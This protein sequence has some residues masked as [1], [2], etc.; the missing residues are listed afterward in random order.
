MY[1]PKSQIQTNLYSN[2]EL[3]VLTTGQL[4]TGDYWSTSDGKFYAGKTPSSPKSTI[5][6]VKTANNPIAFPQA[7]PPTETEQAYIESNP[8]TLRYARLT[9]LDVSSYPNVPTYIPASPTKDDYISG[10]FTRFF[11]KK[12]NESLFIEIS[13]E[14]YTK[15]V[16]KDKSVLHEFYIPFK[17]NWVLS[18]DLKSI[19]R[20]NKNVV[21]YKETVGNFYGLGAYLKNNYLQFVDTTP[22]IQKIGRER[23]YKDTSQEVPTNLPQAYQLGNQA[24]SKGQNCSTCIHYQQGLCRKWNAKIRNEYWCSSW[25]WG[26]YNTATLDTSSP[27]SL[28][29]PNIYTGPTNVSRGGSNSY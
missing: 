19:A 2:A 23:I 6:L 20:E 29:Q 7:E 1:Y 5:E 18:G 25:E 3:T 14:D 28:P 9:D 4:Y 11:C 17:V 27:S 15:L 22:G 26:R 24:T 8:L 12:I 16:E 10:E 13:F 21:E